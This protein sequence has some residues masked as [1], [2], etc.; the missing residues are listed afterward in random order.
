MQRRALL[1]ALTS[2]ANLAKAKES[3]LPKTKDLRQLAAQQTNVK[4]PIVLLASLPGCPFCEMVRRSYLL[5]Y[6]EEFGVQSWQ[7]DTTDHE[8][9]IDFS[10]KM[11]SPAA[12]L[13]TLKI[14]VTPTVLFLDS[15]GREIAP[16][17]EGASV[18]DFYGAYLDERLEKAR[19]KLAA[20]T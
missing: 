12:W 13:R 14:K 10:G 19:K 17:L 18:P 2:L 20:A 3:S 9:L 4:N 5:P 6:K 1:L 7:L 11:T 16:R 15:K 8:A